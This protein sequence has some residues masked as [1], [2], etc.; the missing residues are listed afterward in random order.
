MF[1]KTQSNDDR[2]Y[3][4]LWTGKLS[5]LGEGVHG[6]L[7]CDYPNAVALARNVRVV[8]DNRMG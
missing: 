3:N 7:Y 5:R 2:I 8:A 4:F 6:A 1:Q